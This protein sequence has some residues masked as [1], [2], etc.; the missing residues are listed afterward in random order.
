MCDTKDTA[1]LNRMHVIHKMVVTSAAGL[2]EVREMTAGKKHTAAA[3]ALL[4]CC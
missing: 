3:C 4:V 2:T 1:R